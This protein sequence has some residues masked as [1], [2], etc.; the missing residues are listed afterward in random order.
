MNL[1]PLASV[2]ATS[3]QPSA[4][5]QGAR[6]HDPMQEATSPSASSPSASGRPLSEILIPKDPDVIAYGV[7]DGAGDPELLPMLA[8]LD[9]VHACLFAGKLDE[10]MQQVAPYLVELEG[11][12]VRWW[13]DRY[14][15]GN[16]GIILHSREPLKAVR[17]HLRTISMARL[18]DG[19]QAF[20]RYYDPRVL[21]VFL[22]TCEDE[23]RG[24]F[25]GDAIEAFWVEAETSEEILEFRPD[26]SAAAAVHRVD[27]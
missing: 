2:E 27:G 21:R 16:R 6:H 10:E 11:P 19:S 3:G 24:E 5:P 20:F 14:L 1:V 12:F 22:P 13:F 7:V 8:E 25:F 18:P 9:P 17:R 26:A 15:G 23:D 4:G